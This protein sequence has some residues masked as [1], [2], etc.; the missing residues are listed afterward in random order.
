MPAP[1]LDRIPG[2]SLAVARNGKMLHSAGYGFAN[3]E[4]QI[5]AT[6]ATIF[7]TASI[8]KQFT[9]ALILLLSERGL[10][11]IDDPIGPHLPPAPA[12]WSRITFRHLLSHTSGI[13]D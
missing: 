5:P 8:G 13:S 3:L 1:D 11:H 4:W 7:Q 6:D 2:L 12:A 10:L 9:A